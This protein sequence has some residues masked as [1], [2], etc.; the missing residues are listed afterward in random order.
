M[1]LIRFIDLFPMATGI[2]K[3]G[4]SLDVTSSPFKCHFSVSMWSGAHV[5]IDVAMQCFEESSWTLYNFYTTMISC[6]ILDLQ[7]QGTTFW[8]EIQFQQNLMGTCNLQVQRWQEVVSS[9]LDD[10]WSWCVV[11]GNPLGGWPWPTI[12][13]CREHY[14]YVGLRF[15]V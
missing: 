11:G 13:S 12:V 1:V 6:Q 2:N 15:R 3:A 8:N 5:L 7:E 4:V 14:I 9:S 10:S